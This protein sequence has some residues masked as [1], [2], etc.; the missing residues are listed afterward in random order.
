MTA[1]LEHHTDTDPAIF[2]LHRWESDGGAAEERR[3]G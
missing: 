3:A 2:A 1:M